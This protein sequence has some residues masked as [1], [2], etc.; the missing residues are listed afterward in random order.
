V[1]VVFVVFIVFVVFVVCAVFAVCSVEGLY[2]RRAH[3]WFSVFRV[4][5][6]GV[7]LSVF[8]WLKSVGKWVP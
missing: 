2:V 3:Y 6:L 1:F 7:Y 8:C 4:L 5:L